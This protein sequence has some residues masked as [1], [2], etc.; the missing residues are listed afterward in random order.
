MQLNPESKTDVLA[1][2]PSYLAIGRG[3]IQAERQQANFEDTFSYLPNY[4]T[5]T[6]S[7]LTQLI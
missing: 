2:T 4:L 5:L 1:S 7:C 6:L 3:L